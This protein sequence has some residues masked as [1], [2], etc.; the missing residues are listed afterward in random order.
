MP[1]LLARRQPQTAAGLDRLDEVAVGACAP[2]AVAVRLAG[3]SCAGE[4]RRGDGPGIRR[5]GR[6]CRGDRAGLGVPCTREEHLG[7]ERL[8]E[9]GRGRDGGISRRSEH[10]AGRE[11]HRRPEGRV[12]EAGALGGHTRLGIPSGASGIRRARG[13]VHGVADPRHR[14]RDQRKREEREHADDPE[15]HEPHDPRERGVPAADL[16]HAFSVGR[17]RERAAPQRGTAL[18]VRFGNRLSCTRW[19]SRRS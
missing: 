8:N 11:A 16:G 3:E 15:A 13:P 1:R 17:A 12:V 19:R 2:R 9:G 10:R 7:L 14:R 6:E 5:H 4:R 18:S